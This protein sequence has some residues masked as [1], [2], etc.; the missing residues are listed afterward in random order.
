[1]TTICGYLG[2]DNNNWPILALFRFSLNTYHSWTL[3]SLLPGLLDSSGLT[4]TLGLSLSAPSLP[5]LIQV[6]SLLLGH[7]F[8][9]SVA[10]CCRWLHVCQTASSHCSCIFCCCTVNSYLSLVL[11]SRHLLHSLY[12]C[13]LYSPWWLGTVAPNSGHSW[14]LKTM[15]CYSPHACGQLRVDWEFPG[16]L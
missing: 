2:F 8:I 6:S 1:M 13:T 14:T 3:S 9:P 11:L 16:F 10:F 15:N 7:T 12:F 4:L 5:V